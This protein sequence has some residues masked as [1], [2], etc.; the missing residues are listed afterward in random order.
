MR[1]FGTAAA[2]LGALFL[3]AC[4]QGV[5]GA[6]GPSPEARTASA[7]SPKQPTS[8]FTAYRI[9]KVTPVI[10]DGADLAWFAAEGGSPREIGAFVG[11]SVIEGLEGL[12]DGDRDVEVKVLIREFRPA[13]TSGEEAHRVKSELVFTDTRTGREIGRSDG[14]F[15]DLIALKGTAALIA[16]NAGRTPEVRLAERIARITTAWTETLSCAS[17]D[18][19]RPVAVAAGEP[20][21]EPALAPAPAPKPAAAA[22]SPEETASAETK[23]VEAATESAAETDADLAEDA[24]TAEAAPEPKNL[25]EALFGVRPSSDEAE[26]ETAEES[27]PAP[28]PRPAAIA[29]ATESA[30]EE[31]AAQVEAAAEAEVEDSVDLAEAADAEEPKVDPITAFFQGILAPEKTDEE[32]DGAETVA[33]AAPEAEDAPKAAAPTPPPEPIETAEVAKPAAPEA[34]AADVETAGAATEAEQTAAPEPARKSVQFAA[35]PEP[36]SDPG[37]APQ[38]RE[39]VAA[40][41]QTQAPPRETAQAGSPFFRSPASTVPTLPQTAL[42]GRSQRNNDPLRRR[43]GDVVLEVANLPAFWDGDETTGGV[44]VALPYVPAYRRAIVTNP[45]NGRTIEANLFWRDPQAGG[46]STLLSSDAAAALGV[47]A[48]QVANLGVKIVAAD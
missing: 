43:T 23:P 4:E 39:S 25:F 45:V 40:Q 3:A 12:F 27:A 10:A 29:E 34:D 42:L 32:A 31:S 33:A 41:A 5:N 30:E 15:M 13:A 47:A 11:A 2:A 37:P 16:R 21:P 19:P 46:G 24:A 7:N 36:A 22:P 38:P 1:V 44:W 28:E 8:P 6:L 48:G 17:I 26:T 14:L 18:C 9:A 20:A 35:A